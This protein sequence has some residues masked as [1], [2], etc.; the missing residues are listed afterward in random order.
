VRGTDECKRGTDI[1]R[2]GSAPGEGSVD[3]PD[4]LA[5]DPVGVWRQDG[6]KQEFEGWLDYDAFA[7]HVAEAD[8]PRLAEILGA[9]PLASVRAM[10][11]S[12]REVRSRFRYDSLLRLPEWWAMDTG[13]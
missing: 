7:V 9:I 12:V 4:L 2:E 3:R 1:V 5:L 13:V 10:Q 6:V 11:E 8:V